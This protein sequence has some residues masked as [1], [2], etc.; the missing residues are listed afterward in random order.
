MNKIIL[1]RAESRVSLVREIYKFD[2]IVILDKILRV[3]SQ[4]SPNLFSVVDNFLALEGE[5]VQP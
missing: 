4:R 1:G 5:L 3:V 2:T